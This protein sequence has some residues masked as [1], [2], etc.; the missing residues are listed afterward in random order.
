MSSLEDLFGKLA[1][2]TVT[3]VSR[4]ALSHA[5]N[6]AIRNVTSYITTQLPKNK[7]DT[8]EIRALQ[9]Q[10]DLKIK[11]LKP[12]IDII[13]RSVADGNTDLEPALEMCNDLKS[14]MD[15]FAAKSMDN[16]DQVKARLKQLLANVDDAIPSLHL[17]LRSIENKTGTT[18]VSPAKLIQA[19]N[20]LKGKNAV[21]CVKLY[22]LFS[23]NQ[24]AASA[25][26]FTWKEEFFKASL[27]VKS[28]G[29]F[30][31]E[32]AI[33]EDTDD[34]RYHE[35][36][37]QEIKR[38]DVSHIDRMYYT[39]SGE[40]LN[41]EDSKSPVLV[42]KVNKHEKDDASKESVV[43][44]KETAPEIAREELQESDWYAVGL[45]T[46]EVVESDSDEEEEEE[47]NTEKKSSSS[48]SKPLPFENQLNLLL[49]ESVVKLA[50]L[51]TTEQMNHI[52]ASD[53]LITLYMK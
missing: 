51:E 1:V 53:E 20:I 4:I 25:E 23:A 22:S 27:I 44:V 9:R 10:L 35:E 19:S 11:N 33:T 3:T 2:T 12:T 39:Q 30:S 50:L 29:E 36:G 45:W 13:A 41:I 5:T 43:E 26:A 32:L 37:E 14:D 42:M 49:L 17:S 40:L 31:Y 8:R 48:S 24:R 38:I 52:N 15:D 16:P 21:F 46:E 34:G 18:A 28:T 7:P 47:E 6:A